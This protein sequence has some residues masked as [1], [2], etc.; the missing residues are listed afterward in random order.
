MKKFILTM[1]AVGLSFTTPV[2][3]ADDPAKLSDVEIAHVA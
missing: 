3:A 2:S 1:F